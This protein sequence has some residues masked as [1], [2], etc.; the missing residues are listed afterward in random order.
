[1]KAALAAADHVS[2]GLPMANV[3]RQH[4]SLSPIVDGPCSQLNDDSST[5]EQDTQET[6][7]I[8]YPGS[9]IYFLIWSNQF[10]VIL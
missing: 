10:L 6:W 7:T 3:S 4:M 5:S 8:S 1:M 2:A 9:D